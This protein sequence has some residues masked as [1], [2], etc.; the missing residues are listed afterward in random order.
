MVLFLDKYVKHSMTSTDRDKLEAAWLEHW[1]E[2]LGNPSRMPRKVMQT[3]LEFMD[4][5][6]D[7]LD[8]QMEWECWPV[9]DNVEDFG[10]EDKPEPPHC[11]D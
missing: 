4:I 6:S 11:Y 9:D 7:I 10:F 3:Y 5:S 2:K 1:K 8:M